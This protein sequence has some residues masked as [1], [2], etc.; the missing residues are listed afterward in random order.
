MIVS[1]A[2]AALAAQ[3]SVAPESVATPVM[4]Q[5]VQYGVPV[6]PP[7]CGHGWD[8]SA[9]DGMCYPNGYLPPQ[10]QAARQ[11]RYYGGGYGGGRYSVPCGHGTDRDSR[12]GRCYPTGTVPPQFQSGRQQYYDDDGY[13]DRPRRYYRY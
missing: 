1:I 13:Y 7:P 8:L 12:D 4:P 11:Y 5:T 3:L 10:D 6:R 2:A 9:R